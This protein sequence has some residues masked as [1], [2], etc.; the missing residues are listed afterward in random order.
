MV[1]KQ[2]KPSAQGSCHGRNNYTTQKIYSNGQPKDQ[3][4][5]EMF[6][7]LNQ[8]LNSKAGTSSKTISFIM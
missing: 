5:I 4:K 2:G 3:I 8:T 6:Y 1:T 7:C